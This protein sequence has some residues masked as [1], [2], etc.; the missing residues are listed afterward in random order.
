M[1]KNTKTKG[2]AKPV[3][4]VLKE[5]A[6]SRQDVPVQPQTSTQEYF[7]EEIETAIREMTEG[8]M[9]RELVNLEGTRAWFAI[10]KYNQVRLQQSQAAVFSGDPIKDPTSMLR[11]QGVMLGLSDL[12]NAVIILKQEREKKAAGIE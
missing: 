6:E 2:E 7:T 11:S 5:V 10:L 3:E 1:K 4:E 9:L 8:E 12:Q